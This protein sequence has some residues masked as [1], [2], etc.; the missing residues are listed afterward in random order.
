MSGLKNVFILS[1]AY[2]GSTMLGNA[3]NSHTQMVYIGE[4]SRANQNF[5]KFKL[6]HIAASCMYCQIKQTQCPIFSEQFYLSKKYLNLKDQYSFISKKAKKSI[7]VDGS[8]HPQWLRIALQASAV[9]TPKV[10][11]LARNPSA[12]LVSCMQR[13]IQPLWLEANA[14]RDV[15]FDAIRTC[16]QHSIPFIV[17][18]FEDLLANKKQ[19]LE[20]ICDFLNVKFQPKMLEFTK[21]LH[22]IGGNPAAY[23]KV[24]GLK[25]LKKISENF[26]Q[27]EFDINPS[28]IQKIK[29]S[30]PQLA[31]ISQ[32]IFQTPM[33]LDIANQLG[34]KKLDIF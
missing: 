3:L 27:K 21:P 25:T 9:K 19:T 30:K 18:R 10:I 24:E 5:Q 31:E 22:A 11:I 8:K 33:L 16:S 26:S 13:G 15:Y 14:W 12:Y 32:I 17:I 1:T 34:Y 28:R 7:I 29:T 6:D 2:S 4:L 23:E 20:I